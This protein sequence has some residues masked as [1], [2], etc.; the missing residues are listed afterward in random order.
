MQGTRIVITSPD[1]TKGIDATVY[2]LNRNWT[3][4]VLD[5]GEVIMQ[6]RVAHIY[7]TREVVDLSEIADPKNAMQVQRMQ[8]IGPN[9]IVSRCLLLEKD[10]SIFSDPHGMSLGGQPKEPYELMPAA[11]VSAAWFMN[12]NQDVF[13]RHITE[14][15]LS[16][17]K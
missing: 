1:Q 13:E 17:G 12:V 16:Q 4:I 14:K 7:E 2:H 11:A 5:T 10:G 9:G 15:L 6:H 8:Q 3:A